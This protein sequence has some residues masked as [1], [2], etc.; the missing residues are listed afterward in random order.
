MKARNFKYNTEAPAK[1]ADVK[2]TAPASPSPVQVTRLIRQPFE[3]NPEQIPVLPKITAS[4]LAPLKVELERRIRFYAEQDINQLLQAEA[5]NLADLLPDVCKCNGKGDNET[6]SLHFF[7]DNDVEQ[8]SWQE[9]LDLGRKWQSTKGAE[10][11]GKEVIEVP[12]VSAQCFEVS[13]GYVVK[14]VEASV[15]GYEQEL[16]MYQVTLGSDDQ[17]ML[18]P[19]LLVMF[20]ADDPFIFAKRVAAALLLRDQTARQLVYNLCLDSMPVSLPFFLSLPH[21]PLSSLPR[22][23]L[24][25]SLTFLFLQTP[26]L[27]LSFSLWVL[28]CVLHEHTHT[29][30]CVSR[31]R[32]IIFLRRQLRVLRSTF[33]SV[34][35]NMSGEHNCGIM[36]THARQVD[37]LPTMAQQQMQRIVGKAVTTKRLL[38]EH[39]DAQK[40][41][42]NS[43][44]K[45]KAIVEV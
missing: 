18:R 30:N 38:A 19:R 43:D 14:Y 7:D 16:D 8:R 11:E 9:W 10:W 33:P 32:C 6:L 44:D 15:V 28:T 5:V 41:S 26:C 17:V 4:V 21:S 45:S 22:L 42:L 31:R 40:G 2:S 27:C 3:P 13:T 20:K 1:R 39:S 36:R 37:F 24:S 12:A 25:P 34:C 29:H 23:S 35:I